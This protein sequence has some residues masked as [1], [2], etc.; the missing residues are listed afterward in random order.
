M[1]APLPTR[2]TALSL[3]RCC[4]CLTIVVGTTEDFDRGELGR[5]LKKAVSQMLRDAERIAAE[6]QG[7]GR[8][9]H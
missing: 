1:C 9:R 4:T 3:T 2:A 6:H 7:E 8:A 5:Q